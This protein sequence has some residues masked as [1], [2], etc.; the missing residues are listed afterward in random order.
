MKPQNHSRSFRFLN[1]KTIKIILILSAYTSIF[2]QEKIENIPNSILIDQNDVSQKNWINNTVSKELSLYSNHTYTGLALTFL[3]SAA[4][5]GASKIDK[6]ENGAEATLVN[7][8]GGFVFLVG[9]VLLIEAPIH[10]KRAG[11]LIDRDGL[12]LKIKL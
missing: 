5:Y 4:F 9:T 7:I 8:M 1:L 2:S 11:L 3:G 6:K 12:K 10:I